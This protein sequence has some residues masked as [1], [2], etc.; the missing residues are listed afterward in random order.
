MSDYSSHIGI[1][2]GG[3]AGLTAGC[4]LL[5]KGFKTVIFER[6]KQLNE[7][8]AGIS[9][10]P[11]AIR[12][13]DK[14]NIKDKFIDSSF[15]PE[16]IIF[17][18]KNNKVG[19]IEGNQEFVTSTRQ[20]LLQILYNKYIQLGGEVLFNHDYLGLDQNKVELSFSNNQRYIVKHILG[21]DGIKSPIREEFFP[22]SGDPVYSGYHAWRAIGK[23]DLVDGKFYLGKGKHIVIYP[24]NSEGK[25]SMTAV[26]KNKNSAKDSWRAMGTKAEMLDD[27]KAFDE[28]TFS[29]I[30]SS[31]EIY[32]WGIY[33]RPPLK[34]LYIKNITLLGDAAHPMVPFLGQ[35]GC[36]AIE[37]G[38]AF[39]MLASKY[40]GD[41]KTI[42][43]QYESL[44]LKRTTKMQ[45]RSLLQG[46]IYHLQNPI[47]IFF[48]NLFLRFS[49]A[50]FAMAKIWNYDI[51]KE[52]KKLDQD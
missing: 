22:N 36:M 35:G 1:L 23:G 9:I 4:T 12:I 46:K 49:I 18:Y 40:Q 41:F 5:E 39:G 33:I 6:S 28:D 11:N 32:K 17:H 14:L 47:I 44:R 21:C 10:S 37:D 3:I 30:D 2:G 25:I 38:Y 42:Q 13:L 29:M 34:S 20:N 16:K 24:A 48:R 50:K 19:F 15:S 45:A 27:F 26:V 43:K 7:H 8:G 31:E 51:N 52:I